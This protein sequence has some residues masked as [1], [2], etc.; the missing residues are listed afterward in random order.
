MIKKRILFYTI[1][2]ILT[3]WFGIAL[4]LFSLNLGID[5]KGG[6]LLE[7][8]S[9]YKDLENFLKNLNFRID[10]VLKSGDRF[11]IKGENIDKDVLINEIKKV[12][13]QATILSSEEISPALSSELVKKSYL[14]VILVLIGISTY[15]SIVFWD[16]KSLIPGYIFGIVVMLTLA[17]D[18]ISAMG[19]FITLSHYFGYILDTTII[20][21]LL[22]I[23]GFSVHDT[24]VVLDRVRE[25][26]RKEGKISEEL[27]EKSIRQTLRR[28]IN[29]SLT[30]ILAVFPILFMIPKLQAFVLT[31]IIGIIIGTYSSICISSPLVYDIVKK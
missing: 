18:V 10:S 30:T 29:T 15:I 4:N 8:K 26:L 27:F 31:L 1:S 16:R 21:A 17:H 12:D 14:A 9:N 3:I 25:N 11:I 24:I 19:I 22:V 5:L 23:A 7:I 13:P 6:Q 28:S 2:I 20:I